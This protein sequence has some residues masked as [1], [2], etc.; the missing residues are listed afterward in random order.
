MLKF[1]IGSQASD[2]EFKLH[3]LAAATALLVRWQSG[4][5]AAAEAAGS[6]ASARQG[7][8]E[9]RRRL[10]AQCAERLAEYRHLCH[11]ATGGSGTAM[12]D[13]AAAID[14]SLNELEVRGAALF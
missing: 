5:R 13:Q 3:L 8:H 11:A 14:R 9:Q 6:S 2:P 12:G 1:A 10:L 4:V 7:L